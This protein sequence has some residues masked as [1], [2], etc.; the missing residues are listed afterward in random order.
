MSST[1]LS[2]E[3]PTLDLEQRRDQLT[4][5]VAEL[6]W[7]LGGLVY[8]MAVRD[9]IRVD[10]LIDR[11]AQ[12]QDA[13]A[14]LN[15]IERIIAPRALDHRRDVPPLRCSRTR[16]VPRSAGSAGS[17][18]CARSTPAPF[19]PRSTRSGPLTT[20]ARR[21]EMEL[22]VFS[23]ATCT[24]VGIGAKSSVTPAKRPEVTQ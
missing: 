15:E 6:Q 21:Y 19:T 10:L 24:T 18:F 2:I 5:R 23:A 20:P 16:A 9:R 7:D 13:D 22:I 3:S 11:A 4:A 1:S 12:L 14:E 8:E 17:R